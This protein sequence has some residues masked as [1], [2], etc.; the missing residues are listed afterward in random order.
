MSG[1]LFEQAADATPLTTEEREGLI[2]SYITLRSELNAAEQANILEADEW[3]FARRR[4]V[5]AEQFLNRLHKRMFGKVWKW[6]GQFR[7]TGKKFGIVAYK[8]P[9]ELRQLVDNTRYWTVSATYNPDEIAAR[10]HHQ[11]VF[12]HPYANGNERHARLAT[13]LLLVS[14]GR[15]RFSWGS[16]SLVNMSKTSSGYIEALRAADRHDYGPLMAFVRS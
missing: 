12:I 1:D 9:T 11:L 3:A 10:F 15:L 5:L 16:A 4:N 14:M 13:D 6:A 7:R 2:P 8:I